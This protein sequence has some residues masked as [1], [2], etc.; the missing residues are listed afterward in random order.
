MS[1]LPS[2]LSAAMRW[3]KVS[4]KYWKRAFCLCTSSPRMRFRNLLMEQSAGERAPQAGSTWPLP[5][6]PSGGVGLCGNSPFSTSRQPDLDSRPPIPTDSS[7]CFMSA[8]RESLAHLPSPP[9]GLPLT[10][11]VPLRYWRGQ[12]VFRYKSIYQFRTPDCTPESRGTPAHHRRRQRPL[13]GS[14][15]AAALC[16]PSGLGWW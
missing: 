12:R 6:P 7:P 14:P 4:E 5:V 1:Y 9:G 15:G 13:Q 8:R 16:S 10:R 3:S 2:F 11:S